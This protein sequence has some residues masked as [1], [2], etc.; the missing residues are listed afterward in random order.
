MTDDSNLVWDM[1]GEV[2]CTGERIPVKQMQAM[3]LFKNALV[4][5]PGFA[6]PE[7]GDF[8][9]P[10]NSPAYDIGFQPIDMSDVGIRE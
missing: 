6:D 3:G 5:D 10:E 2:F 8:T 1:A 7:N 4:A 9:L